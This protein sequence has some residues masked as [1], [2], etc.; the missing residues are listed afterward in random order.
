[1]VAIIPPRVDARFWVALAF[2]SICGVNLGDLLPDSFHLAPLI[3]LVILIAA[4]AALA[5]VQ[6]VAE[7][8]AE[9]LFWAAVLAAKAAAT[10]LADFA[11]HDAHLGFFVVTAGLAVLLL[12]GV[13]LGGGFAQAPN[14]TGPLFWILLLIAGALGTAAADWSGVSF[15]NPKVGFPA[16]AAIETG[17]MVAALLISSG[18]RRWAFW[19]AVLVICAWGASVGDIAKFLLTMPVSLGG[20]LALLALT[21]LFWRPRNSL[22][23][24]SSGIA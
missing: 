12:A 1:M 17:L 22:D 4:L 16:T 6:V 9:I 7:G 23:N 5:V 2:A 15:G 13:A 14:S 3:A 10:V 18:A 20:S 24:A 19:P 21:V 8:G 11:V